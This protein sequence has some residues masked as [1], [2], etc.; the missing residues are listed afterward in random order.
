MNKILFIC[1]A[2]ALTAC[3]FH[4]KGTQGITQP[5]PYRD[6]QIVNGGILHGPLETALLRAD[7]RAVGAAD[8]QAQIALT[9]VVTHRDIYTIT[10]AAEVNEYRLSL[11]V[12]AQA[13]AGGQNLGEPM[14]VSVQR[15]INYTN[16]EV[17]G[18]A[19]EEQTVWAEMRAD[20]AGQIVRRLSF[21]KVPH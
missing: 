10:Y 8:A 6:W 2:F 1:S 15:T 14:R 11:N 13:S 5:L 7:G 4:L 12:E 16:S 19:E 3:G 18:K 21:L 20:A 9:S 17:L